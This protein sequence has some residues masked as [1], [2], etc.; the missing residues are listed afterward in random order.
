M[1]D[2]VDEARQESSADQMEP[3]QDSSSRD[4]VET[5]GT[6]SDHRQEPPG[7]DEWTTAALAHAS[8]LVTLILA[9]AGGVGALVGLLV[10]LVI[11]ISYRDRSRFVALH[12]LQSLAYQS[13]GI[14]AYGVLAAALAATVTLAWVISGLLSVVVVGLLLMPVALLATALMVL[15]LLG[16]P[17]VWAGYGLY[18]AYHVYE[19]GSFRYLLIG[20]WIEREFMT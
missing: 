1:S 6:T 7:A 3:L 9:F 14:V 16:V 18:A 4:R 17:L 13:L 19:R 2:G 12:A 15:L 10:P 11:Y 5:A 20:D 8:V